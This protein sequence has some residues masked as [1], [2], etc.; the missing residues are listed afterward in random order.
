MLY[1]AWLRSNAASFHPDVRFSRTNRGV[2]YDHDRTGGMSS[3]TVDLVPRIR[4]ILADGLPFREARMFGG[5][6]FM[7]REKMIVH[8]RRSGDLL[9]R[10]PDDRDAELLT[11]PGAYRP[12]MG[13]GRSMG[14]GWIG[15]AE[16]AI[17][18]DADLAEWIDIA[19]AHNALHG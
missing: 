12:E 8:A 19:L 14:T 6:A 1:S 9:V 17:A 18:G 11:R 5:T 13:A 2:A 7:V 3:A 16:S 10:V 4:A 15:V